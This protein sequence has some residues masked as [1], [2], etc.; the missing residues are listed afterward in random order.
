MTT[1]YVSN[2]GQGD[3]CM[4]LVKRMLDGD[5][6]AL[7]RL[8]SYVENQTS[9][10]TE[11]MQLIQPHVSRAYC[12]GF[13]GP[14]GVGK[15]TL[16]DK[17]TALIRER[18]LT[19]GIVAVDPTSAFSHGAVLGDRIRMERHYLDSGVFI[20]SM[21]TRGSYGG[22]PSTVRGVINVLD[23]S[24]K[25]FILVETV[26]VGQTEIDIVNTADTTVVVLGPEVG[27]AIQTMKAGLMEIADIFVVNKAD[28]DGAEQVISDLR[29]MLILS[30]G[31]SG[32]EVPILPTQA[33]ANVGT[34]QL[35]DAMLRHRQ[36]LEETGAFASRR[37]EQRRDDLLRNLELR[38][39]DRLTALL[40]TNEQL[41]TLQEGVF[42]GDKDPYSACAEILDDKVLLRAWLG[43]M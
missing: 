39:R 13:T 23:A 42:K 2:T 6:R 29:A 8:I 40:Q 37:R 34:Q 20:R 11:I 17:V 36:F 35:L 25:D 43:E 21:A 33:N 26:G 38:L 9:H 30:P 4:E 7:A 5:Q 16:V 18:N 12:V 32:W 41:I 22:L 27:D 14:P 28:R 15:S 24:G 10:V 3:S 31:R 19:V 1:E